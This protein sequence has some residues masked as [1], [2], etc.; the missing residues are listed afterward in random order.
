MKPMYAL[1]IAVFIFL[2]SAE[3]KE[4]T[5]ISSLVLPDIQKDHP[6]DRIARLFA[7]LPDGTDLG[8]DRFVA[9]LGADANGYL[10]LFGVTKITSSKGTVTVDLAKPLD[11]VTRKG[12]KVQVESRF[13]FSVQMQPGGKILCGDVKGIR[14]KSFWFAILGWMPMQS[15]SIDRTFAASQGSSHDIAHYD[16]TTI[17]AQFRSGVG[18]IERGAELDIDGRVLE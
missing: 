13:S 2:P 4:R 17:K 11:M 15:L 12:T 6:Y 14:V 10:M 9:T 16:N 18:L 1:L 8:P 5:A 7:A 3:A